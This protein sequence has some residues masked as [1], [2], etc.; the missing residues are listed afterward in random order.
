MT[1]LD[2]ENSKE[3]PDDKEK[4]KE[5]TPVIEPI[6]NLIQ[7]LEEYTPTVRNVFNISC[8]Q[9]MWGPR[10]APNQKIKYKII[11]YK[12]SLLLRIED[13]G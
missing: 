1:N 3:I 10:G 12:F 7:Q 8:V 5:E 9:S 13:Y 6:I 11:K 2:G 4:M